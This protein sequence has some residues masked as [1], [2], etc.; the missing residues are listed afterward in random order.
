M[1]GYVYTYKDQ[2]WI[3][4]F[5]YHSMEVKVGLWSHSTETSL[6]LLTF[7]M[8]ED[9][10]EYYG[11]PLQVFTDGT[12]SQAY[13]IIVHAHYVKA[14]LSGEVHSTGN[15]GKKEKKR[16]SRNTARWMDSITAAMSTQL[17]YLKDQDGDKSSLRKSM[18]VDLKSQHWFDDI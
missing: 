1:P 17:E 6:M 9:C 8:G 10:W 2:K 11:W 3:M 14:L 13:I 16:T 15:I 7:W 12:N 18:Y 4:V 5:L